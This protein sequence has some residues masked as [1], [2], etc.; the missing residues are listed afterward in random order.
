MITAPSLPPELLGSM[1]I[2]EPVA[3]IFGP[4][5]VM[6]PLVSTPAVTIFPPVTLAVA[7]IRP[8]VNTLPP[9]TLPEVDILFPTPAITTVLPLNNKLVSVALT[10]ELP[11]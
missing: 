6:F 10:F 3:M 2:V 4:L 8:P 11:R 7:L 1:V 9:E 5:I